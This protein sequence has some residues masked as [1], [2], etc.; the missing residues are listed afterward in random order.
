MKTSVFDAKQFLSTVSESAGVYQM[1]N[2][3]AKILY[4]GKAKNLKKRLQ[5]YFNKNDLTLKQQK[6]V[7]EIASIEVSLTQTSKEALVLEQ[8]LIKENKPPYNVLLRDDKSY[9]YIFLSDHE[10]PRLSLHRG[11]KKAKGEYF[12]PFPSAKAVRYSLDF[13]QKT[14]KVRQCQDSYYKNRRRPCLQY[15]IDRCPAPCCYKVDTEYQ[16]A[17]EYTRLFLK[18]D[19]VK[20][21]GE[22]ANEMQVASD[23]LEFER[24][25]KLR[26][27]IQQLQ[28]VQE[29]QSAESGNNNVDIV[30]MHEAAGLLIV[31][32]LF[33][34]DGRVIGSKNYFPKLNNLLSLNMA[35]ENFI[36]QFYFDTLDFPAE[37]IL[38]VEPS[39]PRF[40]EN[41][42]SEMHQRKIQIKTKVTAQRQKWLSLCEKNAQE[43]LQLRLST[44]KKGLERTIDLQQFLGLDYLPKKIECFDISHHGGEQTVASCVVFNE[45]GP[46][47]K[48]YRSFNIED[49][50]AADDYAAIRQVVSR[51]YKRL[52]KESPENLPD[53]VL[54]DGGKGQLSVAHDA[55]MELGLN[56]ILL[57]GVSKGKLRKAGMETLHFVDGSEVQVDIRSKA[58]HLIQFIRDESHR[59]ALKQHKRRKRA[60]TR[61][62]L[63]GIPGVG[64]KRRQQ[65]LSYFGGLQ[66]L[67]AA[68]S[69][70]IAQV[71]GI[72]ASLAEKIYTYLQEVKK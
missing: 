54:I 19:S 23:S 67:Q 16:Q 33:V 70:A 2:A 60:R 39:N 71:P 43:N 15:Q 18:G 14:F 26:D 22:L 34:R 37:I 4:V 55:M 50:K 28:Y 69:D 35:M 29:N 21:R 25:A 9:P 10:H 42:L 3:R 66:Q 64:A 61:S 57:I 45:L 41:A 6:L 5:S 59:F 56:D 20:L 8:N 62:P 17:V 31:H 30:A 72:S 1:Y 40:V 47:K 36:C 24:A 46:Q 11:A 51:R 48:L 38:N 65:L 44:Q 63:E 53:L 13:L 12:G 27:Q 49:V 58:L 32:I 68:N 52:L 7:S